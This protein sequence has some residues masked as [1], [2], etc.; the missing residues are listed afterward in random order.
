MSENADL[1]RYQ[2]LLAENERLK[3]Q[4]LA[5]A[6]RNGALEIELAQAKADRDRYWQLIYDYL[7]D[8]C[9]P[10]EEISHDRK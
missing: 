10:L 4:L 6:E 5:T 1:E 3:A 2:Q 9:K 8:Q 7:P